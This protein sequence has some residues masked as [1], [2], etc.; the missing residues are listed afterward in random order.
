MGAK[1]RGFLLFSFAFSSVFSSAEILIP[2]K[3][4][5]D[6]LTKNI[7][8]IETSETTTKRNET[9]PKSL[10]EKIIKCSDHGLEKRDINYPSEYLDKEEEKRAPSGFT[11]MRGK[12]ED[13]NSAGAVRRAPLGF[14]GMRGK[15][16]DMDKRAPL[17]F[18]GMRGKKE[19]YSENEISEPGFLGSDGEVDL[20]MNSG[21]FD[22][23]EPTDHEFFDEGTL[24][25]RSPWG[26]HG[27]R[28][29]KDDDYSYKRAMGF[30][31]MRGKKSPEI[32]GWDQYDKRA[33]QTA[34][35]GMRGE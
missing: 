26:F 20:F 18:T 31:G 17:G 12:K 5:L 6:E 1:A 24:D 19:E 8:S 25:K 30:L 11:G 14:T 3:E 16:E 35:F 21:L 33:P 10:G 32:Y 4:L 29:R 15:K 27:M 7:E 22:N 2:R 28:G 23:G 9:L 13:Y 34:F